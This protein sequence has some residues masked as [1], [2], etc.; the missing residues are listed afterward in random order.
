MNNQKK[1]IFITGGASGL[2]LAVAKRFA[3]DGYA[4]A[5]GDVN[6]KRA[7]EALSE[8][9]AICEDVVYIHCDVTQDDDW[10][11]A[12][13]LLS[14]RWG[15]VDIVV[16]NAGVAGT[17]GTID[18]VSLEDWDTVLNINLMGVV[19]GCKQFTP[20]F[21]QQKQGYFVN[22]AS[23]AGLMN[24]PLMSS[25]NVSKAGVIS[26]S[27]TLSTELKRYGIGISVVCPAFFKTNLTETLKSHVPGLNAKVEKMMRR[28]GIT[29][30]DVAD[31]IAKAVLKKQFYVVTHPFERKLWYLK[32]ALP[33]GFQF[34]MERQARRMFS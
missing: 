27:E 6:E 3:A 12:S 33:E 19:R 30:E 7:A 22:I 16:N 23:A 21:K 24:A 11:K 26:L 31:A 29:A 18:E 4:I 34:L 8:L 20:M 5:I 10:A 17:A 9:Q 28:S 14:E 25:Y 15:G 2:G 13:A 1:R 32:R